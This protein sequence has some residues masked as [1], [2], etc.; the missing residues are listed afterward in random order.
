VRNVTLGQ[1]RR[2]SVAG[3]IVAGFGAVT[4][5][6]ALMLASTTA[7][8]F[9]R[10]R[11]K[12]VAEL[13]VAAQN[14]ADSEASL[15]PATAQSLA[16][17]ASDPAIGS[18]DPQRCAATMHTF[19][20][21]AA[22]ASVFVLAPDGGLVCSLD[23]SHTVPAGDWLAR[24]R[25]KGDGHT[26]D[27]L[28]DKS[29]RPLTGYAM[30][31]PPRAKD[32]GVL[33]VMWDNATRALPI[34]ADMAR[35]VEV[36]ELDRTRGIVVAASKNAAHQPGA[37]PVGSWMRRPLGDDTT[38]VDS[39]GI[40]RLYQEVYVDGLDHYVLAAIPKHTAMLE[41]REELRWNLIVAAG[42]M[43][44]VTALGFSLHRRIAQ[45]IKSLRDA[46]VAAA[47]QHV[48]EAVP[49]GPAEIAAVA[50]AFNATMSERGLLER[51]LADALKESQRASK[52]KSEFLANMSHE[53]RTPMN[54]VLG[55]LS[56]LEHTEMSNE[57]RDCLETMRDSASSLMG[58]LNELLDFS[59]LEAGMLATEQVE[60]DV[61]ELVRSAV[62]PWVRLAARK[63]VPL[64]TVVDPAVPEQV[65]G[66]PTRVRQILANLTD[67][68]VKFTS[69]GRID[70]TATQ[71]RPNVI[72]FEVKDSGIGISDEGR[73]RL[74]EPFVQADGTTT[75]RYGG[76]GLGLAIC[77]QL[78]DIMGGSIGV[79]SVMGTGSAF[80]FELPL[81]RAGESAPLDATPLDAVA[82][83]A[84]GVAARVLVVDDNVVNQKVATQM[85]RRLGY[86]VTTAGDGVE[87]L[88]ALDASEFDFVL[89]DVQMP[90]MDGC[91][92]T[93]ELRR[94]GRTIPIVAMTAS[95][96]EEDR[97]RCEAVGMDGYVIKPMSMESLSGEITRVLGLVGDK[98]PVASGR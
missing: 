74:F 26:T 37:V 98:T 79:D 96:L 62:G 21:Y 93:T 19:S 22:Q 40:E 23:G 59:K 86:D 9:R 72:R 84:D 14:T 43:V 88:R 57:V 32:G 36:I 85:L 13:R 20:A 7:T 34:P 47:D 41:A 90:V 5:A 82:V 12:S 97:K 46:I 63:K 29:G 42:V 35:G 78:A 66:D 27:V 54:G 44:L 68:A 31:V 25:A 80:W 53:I 11:V 4:V 10:E 60:F 6:L 61:R 77:R 95:A 73:A 64:V 24:T 18:F 38:R 76:T 16:G 70:V 33:L 58:I 1:P 71:V 30:P 55:M 3:Y 94:R 17:V 15:V 45:P 28:L 8:S 75:R 69:G 50:E 52:L 91:E 81:P 48:A 87:A 65:V 92:A 83:R 56:L 51:N 2:L 67:N 39:D 49:A 89:M